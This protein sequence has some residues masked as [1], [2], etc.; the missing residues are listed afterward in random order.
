ML[1]CKEAARL[2]SETLDRKINL[3][4]ALPLQLH[5]AICKGCRRYR[6]QISFVRAACRQHPDRPRDQPPGAARD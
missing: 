3:R 1:S 5:L 6:E 2:M 4:E